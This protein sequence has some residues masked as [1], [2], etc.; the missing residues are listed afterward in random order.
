MNR[1]MICIEEVF[2]VFAKAVKH[3][4]DFEE[5]LTSRK[6]ICLFEMAQ[7]LRISYNLLIF[8]PAC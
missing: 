6:K 7:A 5:V 2:K 1:L 8:C 3:E 4:K